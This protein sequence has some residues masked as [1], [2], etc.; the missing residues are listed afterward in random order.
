[1]DSDLEGWGGFTE[2][3]APQ[4]LLKNER[5][6]VKPWRWESHVERYRSVKEHGVEGGRVR[7]SAGRDEPENRAI[8]ESFSGKA[9]RSQIMTS[10][11]GLVIFGVCPV[12]IAALNSDQVN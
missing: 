8:T 10:W 3:V 6:V 4:Q 7:N 12:N 5:E 1:M 11:G 9:S 2:R